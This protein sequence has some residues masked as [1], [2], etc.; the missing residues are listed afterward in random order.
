[1]RTPLVIAMWEP[2]ARALGWPKKPLGF[3]DI[4]KLAERPARLGRPGAPGV[5]PVPAGAHQPRLL[6]LR[7]RGG[8]RRVL[9][10]DRQEGGPA[11]ERGHELEGAQVGQGHRALDRPLR[12]HDAVHRRP[13]AQGGARATRSAAAMEEVTLAR[14]QPGPRVRRPNL[15]A[16]YPKEGT[17]Y[18]DSPF[19]V[20]DAP[21]VRPEQAEGAKAF[22]RFLAEKLTPELAAR[23][24]FRPADLDTKPV[25]PITAANGVDPAQPK[26]VLGLPEPRVLGGDQE[27]LARGPQAREH[28]ARPRHVGLDVRG[29]AARRAR[30]AACARSSTAS[31]AGSRRPDDVQRRDPPDPAGRPDGRAASAPGRRHQEPRGRGRDVDLR[32]DAA[33]VRHGAPRW[34]TATTSRPSCCSPTARTPT[35]RR[36]WTRPC[37]A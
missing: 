22:Q 27:V 36:A 34:P 24:G 20:L 9:R 35:R 2:M 11:G 1:M 26:R 4:L 37:S 12:R 33:G 28:P 29:A 18:S 25:A 31:P 32:R 5:R 6:D 16:I 14:L 13:D 23:S 10:G 3:A 17:F 8:R 15:V 21:W 7:P 30:R 19:I